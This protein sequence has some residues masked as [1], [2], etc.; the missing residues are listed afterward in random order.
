MPTPHK[1]IRKGYFPKELPP[2]FKTTSLAQ[3]LD[4]TV[5]GFPFPNASQKLPWKWMLN[6][7]LARASQVRRSLGVPN[8]IT[9][10]ALAKEIADHWGILRSQAR[11]SSLSRSLPTLRSTQGRAAV[12]AIPLADVMFVR[13]NTRARGRYLLRTDI[14]EFYRSVYTH[15]IPWALHSKAIAKAHV[16]DKTLLGN[17][18]DAAVQASQ[19]GQTNGIPIGPDTSLILAEVILGAVDETLQERIGPMNGYRHHDDYELVFRT[20]RG[21]EEA[22]AV[23]QSVLLEYG[24]HLNALKTELVELPTRTVSDWWLYVRQFSFETKGDERPK[25]IEFFDETFRR[26]ALARDEYIVAYAIG[27]VEKEVWSARAWSVVQPL[28]HQAL[29]AEPSAAHK[30]VRALVRAQVEN[31]PIDK[32]LLAATIDSM[33]T[34]HAPFGNASE[35][36]W[37][38]WASMMFKLPLSSEASAAVSRMNDSFVAILALDAWKRGLA[39]N[40]DPKLWASLMTSDELDGEAWLLSYE[41][42]VRGWLPS[43][44]VSD[45]VSAHPMFSYLANRNVRFYTRMR[46]ASR[47]TLVK[48]AETDAASYSHTDDWST[49]VD[50]DDEDE[51]NADLSA[52]F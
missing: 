26:K 7:S 36:A 49:L 46:S 10:W 45:H 27:R 17:R 8:P 43:V 34:H 21:A 19:Y 28:L 29:A 24:L 33:L 32:E 40:L 22:K 50:F 42:R 18:I 48:L 25:I 14:A 51:D 15:S 9:H 5:A 41:A 47:R 2:S 16:H 12:P 38:L 52:A 13:V 4:P 31:W 37:M 20:P 23:L 35:V 39:D 3:A 6:H 44:G 11:R 30:F 1:F